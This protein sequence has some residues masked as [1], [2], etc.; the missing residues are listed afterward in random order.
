[1]EL[2]DGYRKDGTLAEIDL[3]R[4]E[5]VPEGLISSGV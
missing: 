4:G 1:M 3:V 5:P 2:W